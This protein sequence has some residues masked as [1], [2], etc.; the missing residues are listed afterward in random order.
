M[1]KKNGILILVIIGILVICAGIG[2]TAKKAYDRHKEELRLTRF[3]FSSLLIFLPS[4]TSY[5]STST[6]FFKNSVCGFWGNTATSVS[7][8]FLL[9]GEISTLPLYGLLSEQIID[10]AVDFPIPLPPS[11]AANS[12]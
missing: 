11:I 6:V 7:K 4:N 2:F 5:K 12:P 3:S 1:K 9:S 8:E 10:K